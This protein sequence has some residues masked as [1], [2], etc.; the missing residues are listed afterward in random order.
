VVRGQRR[1]AFRVPTLVGP[2][3]FRVSYD[4]TKVGTLNACFVYSERPL[5]KL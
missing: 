5:R 3:S 4:P 1:Q 2:F